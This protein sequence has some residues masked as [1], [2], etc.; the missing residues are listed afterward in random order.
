[1]ILTIIILVIISL[2][3]SVRF[4]AKELAERRQEY[5][6]RFIV[7]NFLILAAV[8][9]GIY[10]V[11]RHD[12]K[13]VRFLLLTLGFMAMQIITVLVIGFVMRF[14]RRNKLRLDD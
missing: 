14:K 8:I 1:M 2:I 10:Y 6:G 5:Y 13:P 4:S 12:E 7:I 11:C 3:T 9:T